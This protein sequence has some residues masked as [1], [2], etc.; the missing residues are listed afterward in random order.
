MNRRLRYRET[1]RFDID[2]NVLPAKTSV[3]PA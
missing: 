3:S 1:S 2:I